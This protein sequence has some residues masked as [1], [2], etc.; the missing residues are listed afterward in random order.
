MQA[1]ILTSTAT[2]PMPPPTDIFVTTTVPPMTQVSRLT[3]KI[4]RVHN[5]K[6]D[7]DQEDEQPMEQQ[8]LGGEKERNE[9]E[10]SQDERL[11]LTP[12]D[13]EDLLKEIAAKQG[14]EET[15]KDGR[16]F[17]EEINDKLV[18]LH[19]QQRLYFSPS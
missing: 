3:T 4:V 5:I 9:S 14:M 10:D 1:P 2:I 6:S 17:E 7:S 18:Q 11:V 19:K 12:Q 8:P 13:Q 16:T 15:D